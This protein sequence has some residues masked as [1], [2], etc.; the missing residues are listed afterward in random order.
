MQIEM[1]G[2]FLKRRVRGGGMRDTDHF[3]LGG[4]GAQA[5]SRNFVV[6]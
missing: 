4:G 2:F 3:L 6:L 5:K 1:N